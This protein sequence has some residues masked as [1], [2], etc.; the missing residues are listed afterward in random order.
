MT[1]PHE[2]NT[3]FSAPVHIATEAMAWRPS[4]GGNV[5]RKRLELAGSVEA[6]RV[7][8]LV[9]FAAGSTFPAHGHPDGEEILVLGGTFADEHGDYPAG[10]FLLNP[11]GFAHAPFSREGCTLFV[12]LRQYPGRDKRHLAIDTTTAEWRETGPG[13]RVLALWADTQGPESIRLVRLA[14]GTRVDRH[15]HPGGEEVFILEGDLADEAGRYGRGDWLRLPHGSGHA[16]STDRG[17]LLY[18]KVGHLPA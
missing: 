8:A 1:E 6:G 11:E 16:P 9:K 15:E 18:V 12:K 7:T 13:R 5:W 14:P 3:D 2:R 10:T 17:C 4:P